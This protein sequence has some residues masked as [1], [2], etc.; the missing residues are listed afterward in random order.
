MAIGDN[1][2]IGLT[3]Y[4]AFSKETTFGTYASATS[5]VDFLSCGFR[6]SRESR[7]LDS[8]GL[9]RGFTKRVSLGQ[10][11]GGPFESYLHPEEG[12]LLLANALGG[13]IASATLT[14]GAFT[15]SISAGNFDTTTAI[16]SLSANVKKGSKVWRYLGGKINT[17][18]ISAQVGEPVNVSMEFVFKDQTQLSDDIQT[19]LTL[20]SVLPFTFVEGSFRYTDSEASLTSTVA[21]SVV[22]IELSI[23]NNIISGSEVRSLGSRLP[24]VLPA[25]RR[26]I[27]LK[28]RQR[29]D[30]TTAFARFMAN[31]FGS[32]EIVFAG[33]QI[34]SGANYEIRFRLPKLVPNSPDPVLDNPN[35]VLM[36]EI[37]FDVVADTLTSA[38]RDIGC[39]VINATSSY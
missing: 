14:T 17:M 8:F 36:S 4:V 13:P 31:T 12:V 19:A 21:E 20:S 30:T 34:V 27:E 7:K 32:A 2:E 11:V 35:G 24:S 6:T 18:R 22:G 38:G 16:R 25:T 37:D 10:N 33:A 23:S 15:H 9:N 5:A 26:N 1:A 29:F 28:V 39:T 3:S